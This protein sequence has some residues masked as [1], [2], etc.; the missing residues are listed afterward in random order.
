MMMDLPC[1]VSLDGLQNLIDGLGLVGRTEVVGD[2][3]DRV[4]DFLKGDFIKSSA[5]GITDARFVA[6]VA[7]RIALSGAELADTSPLY[8]RPADAVI[9]K[10]G[11]QLRP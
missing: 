9:P 4:M 1:A 8:L 3:K 7:E 6:S 5:S 2:A 11:G 10:N